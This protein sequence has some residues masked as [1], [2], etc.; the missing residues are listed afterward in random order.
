MSKN[1]KHGYVWGY[2][3]WPMIQI[4]F[5]EIL[6]INEYNLLNARIVFQNAP[7]KLYY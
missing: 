4:W 6:G 2:P 5:H 1:N 3:K 7:G